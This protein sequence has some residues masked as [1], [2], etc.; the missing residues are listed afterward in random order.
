M[1][2]GTCAAPCSEKLMSSSCIFRCLH[3]ES[4]KWTTKSSRGVVPVLFEQH[5]SVPWH[6]RSQGHCLRV[7]VAALDPGCGDSLQVMQGD[8]GQWALADP[9]GETWRRWSPVGA[10]AS[11]LGMVGVVRLLP[12][13]NTSQGTYQDNCLQTEIV[14]LAGSTFRNHCS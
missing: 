5:R 6:L 12:F 11:C 8:Q 2:Q 7:R 1:F 4:E 9:S 13:P 10:R 3:Q 14:F